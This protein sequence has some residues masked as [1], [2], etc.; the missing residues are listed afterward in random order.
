MFGKI[1]PL[2]IVIIIT[3]ALLIFGPGRLAEL[4][5]SLGEGI[6]NFKTSVKDTDSEAEKKS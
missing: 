5:K 4:G 2:E 3:V 6:R 1:G